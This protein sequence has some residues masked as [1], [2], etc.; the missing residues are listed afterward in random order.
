MGFNGN[1]INDFSITLE[2]GA[3]LSSKQYTFVAVNS[4]GQVISPASQG[5]KCIGVVMNAPASGE[6][7]VVQVSGVALVK[8]GATITTGAEVEALTSGQATT[9]ASGKSAGVVIEAGTNTS[10]DIV[11]VLLV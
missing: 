6:Q 5:N 3:D 4:S 8:C 1:Q 2:A 9:L 10:G 11:S 7:A